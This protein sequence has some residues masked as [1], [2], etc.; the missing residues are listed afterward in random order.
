MPFVLLYL[1]VFHFR[2]N[3]LDDHIVERTALPDELI[4]TVSGLTAFEETSP[5]VIMFL[6]LSEYSCFVH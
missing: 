4:R 5:R 1:F 6:S 2:T 3:H